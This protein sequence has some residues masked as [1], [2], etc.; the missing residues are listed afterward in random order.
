MAKFVLKRTIGCLITYVLIIL[1]YCI[2]LNISLEATVEGQIDYMVRSSMMGTNRD[3]L[4]PEQTIEMKKNIEQN[5]RSYY[6]LDKPPLQRI[7]KRVFMTLTF[8]F[9]L[10][11]E[12]KPVHETILEALPFTLLLFVT[13]SVFSVFIGV[14]V[15]VRKAKYSGS[16]YDKSTS[17][18]T[19]IFFGTPAWWMG[20]ILI[21]IFA[22]NLKWF[23]VGALHSS[24]PLTGIEYY[25]DSIYHLMLPVLTLI[26]V[27]FWGTAYL[28]KNMV[29]VPLQEDFIMAARGRGIPEK[30]IL[31]KHALRTA[32]PGIMTMGIL[33]V[34]S[35]I[36][37]DIPVEN[38]FSW[39]GI[40]K[41]FWRALTLNDIP[42]MLGVLTL[43]T[44]LYMAA[45]L[46]L[47]IIYGIL[48][49]R[50]RVSGNG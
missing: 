8:D 35:S 50:I 34:V 19:M 44:I 47:D 14:M 33:T 29:M 27:R 6:W 17:L 25:L 30:K 48:D 2:V 20:S 41:V 46:L 38:I 12:L 3:D 28:V 36:A 24:P 1:M 49:P 22:Y 15:G 16:V 7:L 42:T 9:G 31:K 23:P 26:L 4:S 43:I 11:S 13:S 37:G 5:L 40:G 21:I 45:L 18:F 10:S 39:N 32:A